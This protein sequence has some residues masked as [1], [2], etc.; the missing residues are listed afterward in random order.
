MFSI[1]ALKGISHPVLS[2]KGAGRALS[3][4][5]RASRNTLSGLAYAAEH[6]SCTAEEQVS[7]RR[8]VGWLAPHSASHAGSGS[9]GLWHDLLEAINP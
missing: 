5:A 2:T 1:G 3:M 6:M 9:Q 4:Q 7:K 8:P